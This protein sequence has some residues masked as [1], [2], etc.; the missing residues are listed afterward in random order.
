MNFQRL[1]A[2]ALSTLALVASLHA[3]ATNLF[4]PTVSTTTLLDGSSVRLDGTLNDTNGNS[5]PW[6][7]ELYAGFGECVRFFVT[8]TAFDAEMVVIAPNGTIFRDD[9]GGGSLRPLVK[10]G[11][12]P[13]QGWYTVQVGHFSGAAVNAN[14]TLLY[15]RYNAGNPNCSIATTPQ[16]ADAAKSM[17]EVSMTEVVAPRKLHHP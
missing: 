9:D 15:G 13:A 10:V 5:Q 11:S 12:A 8:S 6:T 3:G 14:F 4:D 16:A 2:P 1:A 7:A 17:K